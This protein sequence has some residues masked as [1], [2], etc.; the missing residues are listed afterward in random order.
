MSV[1]TTRTAE[2]LEKNDVDGALVPVPSYLNS[3]LPSFAPLAHTPL[4]RSPL[5]RTPSVRQPT[6]RLSHLYEVKSQEDE[7]GMQNTANTPESVVRYQP[8]LQ[9]QSD[10]PPEM[11]ERIRL[12]PNSGMSQADLESMHSFQTESDAESVIR[13]TLAELVDDEEEDGFLEGEDGLE[14]PP[15]GAVPVNGNTS[16]LSKGI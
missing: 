3:P 16:D 11:T 13:R 12:G 2:T 1:L 7:Y 6:D 8:R 5:P 15:Q 9:T 10:E 4:A 14:V